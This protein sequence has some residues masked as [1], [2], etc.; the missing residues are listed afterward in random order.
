DDDALRDP[1]HG[2]C[3]HLSPIELPRRERVLT[4][5]QPLADIR[6]SDGSCHRGRYAGDGET[7]PIEFLLLADENADALV[8]GITDDLIDHGARDRILDAEQSR[9]DALS[10]G[11]KPD[12]CGCRG[13]QRA[14]GDGAPVELVL[15]AERDSDSLAR[16][17]P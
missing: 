7:Y 1:D 9:G 13:A 16:D 15:Q 10:A 11:G 6:R 5:T 2:L 14:D 4:E 8:Y 17:A 12:A 3:R